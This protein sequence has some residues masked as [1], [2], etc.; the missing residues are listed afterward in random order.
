[1]RLILPCLLS[2]GAEFELVKPLICNAVSFRAEMWC[3]VNF[4]ARPRKKHNFSPPRRDID[5]LPDSDDVQYFFA[6]I[7]YRYFGKPVVETCTILGG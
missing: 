3:H 1:M 4:L 5:A 2:Q 7:H 6:E